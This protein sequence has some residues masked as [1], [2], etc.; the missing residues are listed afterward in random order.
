LSATLAEKKK[1]LEAIVVRTGRAAVACS[2]G[3][4]STLLL[5]V[6]HDVLGNDNTIA[7]FAETPLLPDGEA[8]AVRDVVNSV[9]SRM[10]TVKLNPL[11]WR[12]FIRNPP[13]RCYLC[14]KK[15][16]R[17]FLDKL[18]G[19]HF[20]ILMDGTNLDDLSDFRPGLKALHEL[21]VIT[22]LA[23]AGMTKKD[24]RRLSRNLNLPNWNRYS[25]SCLATRVATGERISP[26]KLQVIKK[27]E[28]FL[29]GLG[30]LGCR[31]RLA[32]D[33]AFIELLEEDINRLAKK[34]TR[35]ILLKKFN[36]FNIKKVF[37]DLRD[38]KGVS[39]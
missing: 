26:E 1:E 17:S 7:V 3:V 35:T 30:F 22:P 19:L 38:R 13:E 10:L 33:S 9:G 31:V 18:K 24:V 4:D 36:D 2:G 14:K 37:L 6:V 23:A 12:E 27:S 15:I 32:E 5:K 8:M 29:Q 21:G 39:I 28:N 16:Y 25:S 34:E 11:A 20:S